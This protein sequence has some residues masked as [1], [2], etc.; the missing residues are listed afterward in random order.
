MI[1]IANFRLRTLLRFTPLPDSRADIL[2]DLY[3]SIAE[4]RDPKD[5]TVK[6]ITE[7][8]HHGRESNLPLLR[9][10]QH[11]LVSMDFLRTGTR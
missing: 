10:H 4:T 8:A 7:W 3:S 2:R 6:L 11:L 1:N 5:D 9:R